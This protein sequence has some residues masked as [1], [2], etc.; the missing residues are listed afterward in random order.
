M[1][2]LNQEAHGVQE[3][4]DFSQAMPWE[5]LGNLPAAMARLETLDDDTPEA[6]TR[7]EMRYR[8]IVEPTFR[9]T[10]V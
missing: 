5:R 6:L 2:K 8:E 10:H 7:K 1:K 3:H 4:F 9:T